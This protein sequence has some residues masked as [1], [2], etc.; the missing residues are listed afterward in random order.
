MPAYH[1]PNTLDDALRV[2]EGNRLSII[3]GGTDYYPA[4]VG[5]PLDEDVLDVTAIEG[6]GA[7]QVLDGGVRL[8]ALTTWTDIVRAD[9]PPWM[10]LLIQC[11][12]KIG[13]VQTQNSATVVGNICN[14]SPAADGMVCLLAMDAVVELASM[15]GTRSLPVA[16]FVTGVRQTA[17]RPG[18]M[19]T[20]LMLPAPVGAT[21]AAFVKLGARKYMIVAVIAAAAVIEAAADGAVASA[22]IAVGACS[23]VALRLA[24]L[25]AELSGM[26]IS[27]AL[28]ETVGAEH[29]AGLSPISD[30]RASA[31]Y[32]LE[33]VRTVLRRMLSELGGGAWE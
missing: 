32:R 15:G 22:R 9:L 3:A 12:H 16:E 13:A 29:L 33:A 1:R 30:I 7:I 6:L 27:P 2:L 20:G 23:P 26:A 19:V 24:G 14:A 28:G 5:R 17:C 8:G 4:R 10:D 25:E 21:R 11:A 18:E 31:E